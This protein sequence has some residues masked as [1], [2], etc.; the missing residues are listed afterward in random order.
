M[1]EIMYRYILPCFFALV[2][3]AN[4][5]EITLDRLPADGFAASVEDQV[6]MISDVLRATQ[7]VDQRVR[8]RYSGR[9]L[10]MK[11]YEVFLEGLDRL[12]DRALI[13]EE[14]KTTPLNVPDRMVDDEI[15]TMVAERYDNDRAALLQELAEQ[16]ITIEEWRDMIRDGIIVQLMRSREIGERV[17]ASPKQ[18][19]QAYEQREESFREPAAVDLRLI[20]KRAGDDPEV[21]RE[22]IVAARSNLLAGVAFAEVARE[23]SDDPTA[24]S[25]GD[26]GW[27]DPG[28]FRDEFKRALDQLD[29]GVISEPVETPEGFYLLMIEDR[30]EAS[31]KTFDEVRDQIAA[32]LRAEQIEELSRDWLARLRDKFSVIY[33]IPTPPPAP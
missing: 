16:R 20:F 1:I 3:V 25:G 31:V 29:P 8:L 32:E 17:V 21:A 15:N 2:L 27:M 26:W 19:L 12:I 18:I 10:E 33:H 22:A 6:I 23:V 4:A 7:S 30:R 28:Q 13:I 11:R 14:F 5:Q 9:E 24:V